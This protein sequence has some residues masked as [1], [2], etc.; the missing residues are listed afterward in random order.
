M[1][2]RIEIVDP[3][4]AWP[5]AYAAE[6]RR[7]EAALDGTKWLA[8]EHYGSTAVPGL[9]AKPIIDI[10]MAVPSLDAAREA[11]PGRLAQLDYV[12]W[13]DNPKLDRLY[14]VKGMPPYGAKRT[15]H[16]HVCERPSAMWSQLGFR[17][18]LRDH[19][20]EAARYALLKRELAARHAD[21]RDAYT[22]GKGDFIGA[23]MERI[24]GSR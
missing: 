6:R 5:D 22:D 11:F 12:F 24:T 21:D 7:I 1:G 4:P 9:P 16:L 2:D 20:D 14:F 19:P 15:H 3:D 18:Y 10:L 8:I 17:D 23:V 13:S